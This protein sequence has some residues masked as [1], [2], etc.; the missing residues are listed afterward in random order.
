MELYREC[1]GNGAA[2]LFI[3]GALS[4]HTFFSGVA[5]YLSKS[6]KVI[7]Y[8]RKGYGENPLDCQAD[9][10]LAAQ[11]EDAYQVLTSF[12][13][14][15][16]FVVGHSAGAHIALELAIRHPNAVKKLVLIEPSF[17][18]DPKDAKKFADWRNE[19][20]DYVNR[21]QLLRIFTSFQ[22]LI[23]SQRSEKTSASQKLDATQINRMRKNLEAFV[24]GDLPQMHCFVS[25]EAQI[26]DLTVPVTVAVTKQ[27]PDNIFSTTAIHDS[28]YF[29]WPVVSF[30]GTHSSIEENSEPFAKQLIDVLQV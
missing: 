9:Y 23:G 18:M 10:S 29:G 13:A 8:D 17:G 3:H 5:E 27:N 20:M 7:S 19:L 22:A 4:D 12:T 15:P 11:A 21:K 28:A 30:P 25:D 1:I 26:R 16:V 2:V 24:N 6:C 14:E